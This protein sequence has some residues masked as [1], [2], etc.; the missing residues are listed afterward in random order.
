MILNLW[1]DRGALAMAFLLPAVVY[2]I[3]AGIFA[4]ASSGDVKIQ[5]AILDQRQDKESVALIEAVRNHPIV[6]EAQSVAELAQAR[7]MV[8]DGA[9]DVALVVLDNGTGFEELAAGKPAPLM[10]LYD[11]FREISARLLEGVLQESYF[12]ALPSASVR[13]ISGLIE[14]AF[15][16]FEPAQRQDLE[17]GLLIMEERGADS[18]IGTLYARESVSEDMGLPAGVSYYAGAVAM[19]FLLLSAVNG[20]MS[21]LDEKENG[22]FDRVTLAPG[23][24]PAYLQ[25]K[26]AFL[27]LEGMVAVSVIFVVAW[28]VF[29]VDLPGKFLPWL[30]VSA[31]A[32]FCAAGLALLFV[33]LCSSRRQAQS[34]GHIIVLVISALGGSMVPRFL[35]PPAVQDLG[36]FTP[37]TWVLEAYSSA[38]WEHDAAAVLALPL[39]LLFGVGLAA[40]VVAMALQFRRNVNH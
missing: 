17:R 6:I 15:F 13:M 38:F 12:N 27:W 16:T 21:I 30:I 1:H 2:V 33:S 31:C 8:D 36:W 40:S 26:L 20:A 7:S 3:F 11:P 37:N 9:A 39:Y 35:M 23:G 34:L 19:L 25:G 28:L 14:E 4:G 5:L 18:A 32:A 24:V 10:I 22:L 29:G